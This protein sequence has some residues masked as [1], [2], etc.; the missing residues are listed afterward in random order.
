VNSPVL[1]ATIVMLVCA[2]VGVRAVFALP[3]HPRANWVFRVT[4]SWL[5]KDCVAGG[6]WSLYTLAVAPVWTMSAATC[7]SLWPWRAAV[8]H[9]AILAAVAMCAVELCLVGFRKVP[10][11]CMYL[12]GK[13]Q[14][15]LSALGGVAL[16]WFVVLGV[17]YELRLLESFWGTAGLVVALVNCAATLRWLGASGEEVTFEDEFEPAVQTLGL[18]RDGAWEFGGS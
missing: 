9:L 11:T 1:A 13:S 14:L 8:G 15:H 5:V 17:R 4:R 16:L 18:N 7:L 2:I 3:L 6:R 12:P 10:F